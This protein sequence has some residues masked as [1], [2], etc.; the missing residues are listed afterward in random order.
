MTQQAIPGPR[1]RWREGVETRML[2]SAANGSRALCIFEQWVAPGVGA[3]THTHPVEE[4][5]TAVSGVADVWIGDQRLE[6]REGQSVIVPAGHQ[7]GF[8][9]T[10]Q[11]TLHVQAVLA[12]SHFEAAY[13]GR[14]EV[15]RRW[16][17]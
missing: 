6:L 11:Q 17:S 16:L 3:P 12:S 9:N 13:E 8:T 4:V 2:V 15:I 1:E 14:P 5:L 10:V 7:H